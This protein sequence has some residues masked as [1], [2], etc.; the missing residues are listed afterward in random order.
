MHPVHSILTLRRHI[1]L[2]PSKHVHERPRRYKREWV[3]ATGEGAKPIVFTL[4]YRSRGE[5]YQALS[6][7]EANLAN[8]A[9]EALLALDIIEEGDMDINSAHVTQRI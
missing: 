2:K 9:V 7:L 4:R 6:F 5:G 8:R 1:P 3:P